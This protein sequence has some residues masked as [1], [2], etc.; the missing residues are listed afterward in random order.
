[1]PSSSSPLSAAELT[2]FA[3]NGF[4]RLD[5]AFPTALADQ[6]RHI[7]GQLTGCDRNNPASWT[8]PVIRIG[9]RSDPPFVE[10]ANAPRLVSALN[11]IVGEDN[12]VPLQGLGTFPI[13]FPSAASAGD[14]GWH[15]DVSFTLPG[16]DPADFLGYRANAA[17]RGRALLMLFLFSDVGEKDAPTRIRAG[18]HR[19]VA[20]ML[21]PYGPDGASLRELAQHE[22]QE[23]SACHEVA[24]TGAAGTIYLC[25][26]FLVHAAQRHEG[27]TPKFMAQP[28]LFPKSGFD[29]GRLTAF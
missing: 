12:W 11:Q 7:L 22:F 19:I 15:I 27:T 21:E 1:M 29:V 8:E 17:S 2:S 18:S 28:P 9:G 24:A 25:H 4:V 26:P 10:A 16:D 20:K 13:R 5:N 3:R 6:G 23:T 14:D